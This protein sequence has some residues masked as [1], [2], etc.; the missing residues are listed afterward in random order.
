MKRD[1]YNG[2]LSRVKCSDEFRSRMQE[3]LSSPTIE[4]HEYAD[5][6]SGTEVITAKHSWGRFA[7]A[8]AAFVLVCG[9]V[10]GGDRLRRRAH[11][12]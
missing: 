5:S 3:K 8:A 12:P 9:A 11:T 10:C 6:V 2:F 1:E 4:V 7:A